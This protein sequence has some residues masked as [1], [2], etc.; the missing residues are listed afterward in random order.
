M[1]LTREGGG[2]SIQAELKSYERMVVMTTVSLP[3]KS[4]DGSE[5]RLKDGLEWFTF[6]WIIFY[7]VEGALFTLLAAED[8]L[9]FVEEEGRTLGL[10]QWLGIVA[11]TSAIVPFYLVFIQRWNP[12]WNPFFTRS[13]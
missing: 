5:N 6:L 4:L 9:K 7:L 13:R 11:V 2:D 3:H 10:F 8:V 12:R 1:H